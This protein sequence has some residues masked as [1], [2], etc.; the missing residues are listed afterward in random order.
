MNGLLKVTDQRNLY[1]YILNLHYV[2][3]LNQNCLGT[4]IFFVMAGGNVSCVND[5]SLVSC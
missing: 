4:N 1:N 5:P 3:T 2:T